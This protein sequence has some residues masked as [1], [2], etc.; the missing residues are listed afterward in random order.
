MFRG[1]EFRT[2][3]ADIGHI[4]SLLPKKVNVM[5]LTAIA[6][7]A[8]LVSVKSRLAMEDPVIIGL[9]PDRSNIKIIVGPC[10]DITVLCESLA[11][12]L[13]ENRT[14]ATKTVI[15]CRSLKDCGKM[16]A[17]LK[18]LLGESITE[19][20]NLPD[21]FLQFRLIE[22]FTAASDNDMREE[23]ISELCKSDTK[24]RI[25]IAST[26]FGLGIDCMDIARV[27]NYG[28]PTTLEELVQEMGRAGRN[29]N[30]SHAILYHKAI[31]N[32]ISKQATLYGENTSICR[33]ELLFK[34]FLFFNNENTLTGCMCCDLC[35]LLCTCKDFNDQ[36][37]I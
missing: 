24:L 15:F 10:P 9:Y 36:E 6:T 7:E 32:K 20:P 1:D 21:N 28:T 3:F 31:G 37:I 11:K 17:I 16:C 14:K 2:T 12:D 29:G 18:K 8:T 30:Q 5:T 27:I 26:A 33:R 13:I 25:I 4:R 22:V 34:D 35:T 19:P 23:I